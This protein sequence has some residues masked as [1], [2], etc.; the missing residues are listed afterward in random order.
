VF[1]KLIYDLRFDEGSARY[2]AFGPFY[3]G[4]QFPA[5]ELPLFLE[6][7]LPAAP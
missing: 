6:G 1:K 3:V 5:R 4:L 2:A 7:R